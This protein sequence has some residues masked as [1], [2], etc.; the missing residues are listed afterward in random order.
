MT[1]RGVVSALGSKSHHGG[2][3][4]RFE[5]EQF[6]NLP[7]LLRGPGAETAPVLQALKRKQVRRLEG[8]VEKLLIFSMLSRRM[9]L[10]HGGRERAAVR[11]M[12]VDLRARLRE[13]APLQAAAG[14]PL[15]A[16][17][18]MAAR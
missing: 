15:P 18:I 9:D 17:R 12:L 2:V 1:A 14:G 7:G 11:A 5:G 13:T 16:P 10:W 4:V 8:D 6:E 3:L